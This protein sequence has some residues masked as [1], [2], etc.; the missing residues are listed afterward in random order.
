MPEVWRRWTIDVLPGTIDIIPGTIDVLPGTNDRHKD[1][2]RQQWHVVKA[3]T[4]DAEPIT[5][6]LAIRRPTS[7]QS[8]Y[9]DDCSP[10]V[11]PS[12]R[13]FTVHEAIHRRLVHGSV[14]VAWQYPDCRLTEF[15]RTSR[16]FQFLLQTDSEFLYQAIAISFITSRLNSSEFLCHAIAVL[17]ITSLVD[18]RSSCRNPR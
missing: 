2:H 5:S 6:T 14:K 3:G 9:Y 11:N 12:K 16:R 4:K 8:C 7:L 1:S 15:R 17:F 18:F 10:I 13:T